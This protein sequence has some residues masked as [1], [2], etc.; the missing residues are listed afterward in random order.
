MVQT[1][2]REKS[3][4]PS[5]PTPSVPSPDISKAKMKALAVPASSF[6][7]YRTQ[8]QRIVTSNHSGLF[9][10]LDKGWENDS[11]LDSLSGSQDDR[12]AVNDDYLRQSD[13]RMAMRERRY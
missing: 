8:R 5:V 11:F 9:S 2:Q 4:I 1:P 6:C 7:P 13:N 12:D 3:H 10:S